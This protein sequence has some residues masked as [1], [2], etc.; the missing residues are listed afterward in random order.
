MDG[1]FIQWLSLRDDEFADL[2]LDHALACDCLAR[3]R[4][5]PDSHQRPEI[6]DYQMVIAGLEDEIQKLLRQRRRQPPKS[7]T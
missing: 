1:L 4:A 5:M 3:F 6:A 2:C 7:R